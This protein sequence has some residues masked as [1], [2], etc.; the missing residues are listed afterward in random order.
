M[1]HRAQ[2]QII[3][4]R[5]TGKEGSER[6][7]ELRAILLDLPNYRNGPYADIRKWVRSQVEETRARARVVQRDSIAV[8]REGAA[9]VALV[10]PPNGGKSSLL[11]ALSHV[12]VKVG[13]YAFT[14]L[15]PVPAL[16]RVGGVLL[17]LVEIPGLIH[18][19]AQDRGGGRA[20]LGVLREA[21]AVVY[22]HDVN[23]PV[24]SLLE[25]RAEVASAGIELPAL[26]AA[27]KMDD[28][29]DGALDVLSRAVP[30]L[31]VV[32]VSIL[33]DVSLDALKEAIW[34]LCGLVRV[35]L[36]HGGEV[37]GEPLALEPGASVAD[38]AAG[39]HRG[40][41]ATFR[42]APVWG[43]SARFDGQQVGRDHLVRDGDVVE[44]LP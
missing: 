35:F 15:R 29:G 36:R 10:G 39:I 6:V 40:L 44:I 24:R 43:P 19:A 18:G 11:H 34:G 42:G 3:R 23:T 33:D 31:P 41:R 17:Q 12:Q 5:L 14:T 21:D 27:T 7:G 25:V 30:D 13:D 1:P 32:G 22:C 4:R 9:Q 2:M 16:V 28:A 8:R 38:V 20:L 26:L 37:G